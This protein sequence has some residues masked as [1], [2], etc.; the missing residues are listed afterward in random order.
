MNNKYINDPRTTPNNIPTTSTYVRRYPNPTHS[1]SEITCDRQQP[2][3]ATQAKTYSCKKNYQKQ[4]EIY[5]HNFKKLQ[6][7]ST[8]N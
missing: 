4:K 2:K 6:F 7:N 8:I 3:Q 5:I 1:L